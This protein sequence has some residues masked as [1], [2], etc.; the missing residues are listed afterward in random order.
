M[1]AGH[2]Q[3]RRPQPNPTRMRILTFI[4][5]FCKANGY[6]PTIRE[7]RDG[8]GLKSNGNVQQHLDRLLDEGLISR[9]PNRI[10]SII[11][12]ACFAS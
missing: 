4:S 3:S 2:Y 8:V 7:I 5:E 9:H 10:R 11:P 6:S 12:T 1:Q